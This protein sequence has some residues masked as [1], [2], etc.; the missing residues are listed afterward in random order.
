MGSQHFLQNSNKLF[1]THVNILSREAA[2]KMLD[3]LIVTFRFQ[4]FPSL[5]YITADSTTNYGFTHNFDFLLTISEDNK[6]RLLP[7]RSSNRPIDETEVIIRPQNSLHF[8][9]RKA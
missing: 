3:K 2:C 1:I 6:D 5:L 4:I 7:I 8:G 9:R